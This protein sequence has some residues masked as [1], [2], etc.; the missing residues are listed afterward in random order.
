[1]ATTPEQCAHATPEDDLTRP[2]FFTDGGQAMHAWLDRMRQERPVLLDSTSQVWRVLRYDDAT[3][4]LGDW[5][6]FS[7][8]MSRLTLSEELVEGNI[9]VLDPPRH[10]VLRALVSQAFTPRRLAALEAGIAERAARVLDAGREG[11]RMEFVRDLAYPLPL[12]VIADLLGL[13]SADRP[14][15]ERCADAQIR[16]TA[17]DPSDTGLQQ[18][19]EQA[20]AELLDLLR[21]QVKRKRSTPGED[22]MSTLGTAEADGRRLTDE[23]IVTFSVLLLMAGHVTTMGLLSNLAVCMDEHPD[24]YAAVRAD[25]SLIPGAVEETLRFRPPV[26]DAARVTATDVTLHGVDIPRNRLVLVATVSAARDER[27]FPHPGRFDITRSPNPHLAFSHGPHFCLGAQLARLEARIVLRLL[28][29]RWTRIRVAE[30]EWQPSHALTA[31]QRLVL[32]V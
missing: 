15:L 8:D 7:N 28:T 20:M 13:P 27:R 12:S 26:P 30:R 3:Q 23:E 18:R 31:P 24:A 19:R 11:G 10:Q 6:T 32:A 21:D 5:R 29:E 9:A 1:M 22:L 17:P 16:I 2:P 14:V 25:P 4:V